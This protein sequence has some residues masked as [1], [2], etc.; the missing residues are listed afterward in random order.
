VNDESRPEGRHPESISAATNRIVPPSAEVV[1]HSLRQHGCLIGD[2]YAVMIK[3]PCPC[4]RCDVLVC[5]GC[6][7]VVALSAPLPEHWCE[8]AHEMAG[9]DRR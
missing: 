2:R 4:G 8:H 5:S 9:G 7:D 6:F 3:I 1:S